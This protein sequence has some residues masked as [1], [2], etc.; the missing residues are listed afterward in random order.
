MT[1]GQILSYLPLAVASLHKT[2]VTQHCLYSIRQVILKLEQSTTE[3]ERALDEQKAKLE[4]W[5]PLP[6]TVCI[7]NVHVV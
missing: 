4:R 5:D 7:I 2:K 1:V 6:L 3:L